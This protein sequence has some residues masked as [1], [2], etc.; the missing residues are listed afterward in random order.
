VN[1]ATWFMVGAVLTLPCTAAV[2]VPVAMIAGSTAGQEP[3]AGVV[4]AS[5]SSCGD[6]AAIV[7]VANNTPKV[8][9]FSTTQVANAAAIVRVGQEKNIPPRGWVIA[10]ATAM[11]ESNLKNMASDSSR[12]PEVARLSQSVPHDGTGHDHD[13][14]GLFQQR[15]NE[16]AGGWGPV[17]ELMVPANAAAK[18]YGALLKVDGWQGLPLTRAAQKVQRSAYPNAYAKWEDDAARLVNRL[19]GNAADTASSAK[20]IG[21]CAKV[22]EVTSSGWVRP[23]SAPI[24]D[25]FHARGGEHMGVDLIAK[26]GTPIRSAAA[27]TV[28][29]MECDRTERGYDCSHDGSSGEWP[30]GCGWYVDIKHAGGVITRY[31]HMLR[32]PL[33]EVGDKVA[34]GQQIGVVGSTGHSSGPHLHFEVHLGSRESSTA[35]DPVKFMKQHGAPLGTSTN[36]GEAAS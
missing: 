19:S 32:R 15:P 24:G 9:G 31:C 22:D 23:V 28:I 20:T 18:F 26:R 3:K 25:G 34:A 5:T 1:R 13:S 17:K 11:Q 14:V 36:G 7:Q 35:T 8:N 2:V 16:G 12:W 21:A 29:H 33:V 6:A 4:P 30:G 27:G 10:V